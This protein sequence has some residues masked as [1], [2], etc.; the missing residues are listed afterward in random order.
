MCS[1]SN[2]SI[3]YLATIRRRAQLSS[4]FRDRL[5]PDCSITDK[6]DQNLERQHLFSSNSTILLCPTHHHCSAL[7]SSVWTPST[8][9]PPSPNAVCLFWRHRTLR[10]R[11]RETHSRW[12]ENHLPRLDDRVQRS[13]NEIWVK[14]YRSQLSRHQ[15]VRIRC[16]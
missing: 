5:W 4:V 1:G 14:L 16:M 11:H 9:I 15:P 3:C 12:T 10:E 2:A 7:L 8:C 13:P 6:R